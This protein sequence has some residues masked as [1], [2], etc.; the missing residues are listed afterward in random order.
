MNLFCALVGQT[1]RGRKGTSWGHILRAMTT[2]DP[3]WANT[4][5][6]SGLVS[7]EGLVWSVRDANDD[8]DKRLLV[9]EP[10]LASVL[11]VIARRENTLSAVVRQAWDSGCLRTLRRLAQQS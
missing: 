7:G 9:V 5:I 6:M 3:E 10:E 11:K 1:S 2:V 4:R 8:P